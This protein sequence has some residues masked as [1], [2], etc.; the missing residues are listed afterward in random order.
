M[1]FI[2][3]LVISLFE[4][5]KEMSKTYKIMALAMLAVTVVFLSMV[6]GGVGFSYDVIC[7]GQKIGQISDLSVYEDA[8]DIAAANVVSDDASSLELADLDFRL[9]LTVN[10]GKSTAEELSSS[11]LRNS[12]DV[13]TGYILT[14]DG[15]KK[16]YIGDKA[17][18][19]QLMNE[20]L[21]SFNVANAECS[22]SF[23]SEITFSEV[24]VDGDAVADTEE[25]AALV[26]SLDVVTTAN[27]VSTYSVPFE[28]VTSRTSSKKAGYISVKTKGVDGVKEKTEVSTY[29]NGVLTESSVVSDVY[30]TEP[31]NEVI[32]V[33]TGKT[34]YSQ[35]VQNASASG[36]V[37]PLAVKGIVTSHYGER[38]SG[39]H[40]G[41]DI[42][43]DKGVDIYAVK[44]GTVTFSGTYATYGKLVVIDHGNGVQTK[45]AHCSELYVKKGDTVVQGQVIAA[46]GSTGR[47]TGNHLHFE[48]VINGG[49]VNPEPYIGL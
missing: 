12:S 24:Y 18:A 13:V 16:L 32:I 35:T 22:G 45:Y 38:G 7:N 30:V 11:I 36:F 6:I 21:S 8:R 43:C 17:A 3:D 10:G 26:N 41:V 27:T 19:D 34:S 1:V 20:R 28:T 37:W 4:R 23:T 49:R 14:V 29:L 9:A 47:S 25:L 15:E 5:I 48:V 40:G 44:G 31:V 2:Q 42:A 46:V 39:N 33:G